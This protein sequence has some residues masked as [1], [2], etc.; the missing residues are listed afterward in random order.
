M[1]VQTYQIGPY[2]PA[3]SPEQQLKAGQDTLAVQDGEN[4]IWNARGVQSAFGE[5]DRCTGAPPPGRHPSAQWI[6]NEV[7]HFMLDGV[8]QCS[9]AG[10]WEL[11]FPY[12]RTCAHPVYD[13][14][15][16]KWT[17]AY[18]GTRHWFS[19]PQVPY[20]VYYDQHDD[21]WGSYRDDCWNGCIYGITHADNRLVVLL[22][23]TV[24]WSEFDYG[25][26]T[27]CDWFTGAGAQSLALIRYGQ[28]Y[29]VMPY[30][31]G[32]LTFTSM[33]V[34]LT[35]PERGQT[36]DPDGSRVMV[37]GIIFHHE[38]ATFD[39]VALGPACIEHMDEKVVVW[40][41]PQG[42]TQFS[43]TQG[44]GFG[45]V[46]PFEPEMSRFYAET[47]IPQT[48]RGRPLKDVFSL[49]FLR[50]PNWLMLSSRR[51]DEEGY[52]RAHVFQRGLG[53]WGTFTGEHLAWGWGRL[54]DEVALQRNDHRHL[55][56][57][58]PSGTYV[59]LD[60]QQ[61][62]EKCWVKFAPFVLSAPDGQLQ[63]Q[64]VSSV[65]EVRLGAGPESWQTD[66]KGQLHS[67][68]AQD[69]DDEYAPGFFDVLVSAS[70][71]AGTRLSDEEE[72]AQLRQR[73]RNVATYTVHATG[74]AHNIIVTALR[75]DQHF[76]LRH[77]EVGY[78]FAGYK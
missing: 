64:L 50:D 36:L 20:L 42:F 28:P 31:N 7:Y 55:G 29:T 60:A 71:G 63:G 40:M 74:V 53:R 17:Y 4:F 18:V 45:A 15:I 48:Q 9:P 16:Y 24:V 70:D 73:D 35:T 12:E 14:T 51:G 56:Y 37:G 39:H 62:A 76:D 54:N 19:H 65:Q 77:I 59:M 44:G 67:P 23:D 49:E 1:E 68:W 3:F 61:P 21:E 47:V 5:R 32:W 26:L 52:T 34:M 8:Y 6:D 78:F 27:K 75:P 69:E 43:V 33:G 25:D 13:H 30:N 72:Y 22:E 58:M 41:T 46:Q 10:G 66:W 2:M 57:Y 11:V 38:E